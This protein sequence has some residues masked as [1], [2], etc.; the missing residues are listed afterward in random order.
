MRVSIK[1]GHS[2][3]H[4]RME[5]TRKMQG[6]HLHSLSKLRMVVMVIRHNDERKWPGLGY[7]FR[8]GL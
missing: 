4:A 3:P 5:G 7:R 2:K 6:S 1:A 8:V